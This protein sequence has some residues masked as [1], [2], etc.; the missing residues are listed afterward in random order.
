MKGVLNGKLSYT[1][2]PVRTASPGSQTPRSSSM[3]A[4]RVW[5][6]RRT[7]RSI[8]TM[9]EQPP[10]LC[11]AQHRRHPVRLHPWRTPALAGGARAQAGREPDAPSAPLQGCFA[12]VRRPDRLPSAARRAG[13]SVA[14]PYGDNVG[15]G[16]HHWIRQFSHYHIFESCLSWRQVSQTVR[17]Q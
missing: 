2:Q 16:M 15:V 7:G 17:L 13:A 1:W 10:N 12:R 11:P 5:S 6:K 8:F 4:P 14:I 3:G 9:G